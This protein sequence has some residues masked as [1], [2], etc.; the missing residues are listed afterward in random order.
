MKNKIHLGTSVLLI[1][2]VMIMNTAVYFAASS[3][4]K[5]AD[6]DRAAMDAERITSSLSNPSETLASSDLLRAYAPDSGMV[7]VILPN[8]TADGV[9]VSSNA[10]LLREREAVFKMAERQEIVKVGDS[11]YARITAPL[12]WRGGDVAMLELIESLQT[13]DRILDI[14]RIVLIAASILAVIPAVLSARFLSAVISNPVANMTETM[15]RIRES[16][17]YERIDIEKNKNDELND[18][19]ATFNDMIELLEKN[20]EKQEQFVQNASH[21]LK[22]PLTVI[23]SYANLLQ[24][25]GKD[26]PDL[27]EES[28]EAIYNEAVHMKE[29][30]QQLLVLARRDE[31]WNLQIETVQISAFVQETADSFEQAYGRRVQVNMKESC[32]VET[33]RSKLRQLIYIFLDNARKYSDEDIQIE[34]KQNTICIRDKGIGIPSEDINKIFDRFYR[35]D[36]ARTRKTGGFGLGL[37]I[38][39]ELAEAIGADVR[40]ESEEGRGTTAIIILSEFSFYPGILKGKRGEKE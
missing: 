25:R 11:R 2:I 33:D 12:I 13:T 37:P 38:A 39:K 16:G 14:L 24:R 23:E 35:V 19:A 3:M 5:E 30:T 6:L 34:V 27:F 40:I 9:T 7:R 31:S 8:G 22:T 36:K 29:L 20:Y 10:A 4:L 18:M 32:T 15:R 21:E 17:R 28:I 1:V 26:R